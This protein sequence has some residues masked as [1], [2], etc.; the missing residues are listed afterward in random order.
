[1]PNITETMLILIAKQ[2]ER[3][4]ELRKE[5]DALRSKEVELCNKAY[6]AA[7]DDAVR[8]VR[9]ALRGMI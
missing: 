2:T 1:M 9:A 5:N 7:I 4:K 8:V 3:I 6:N